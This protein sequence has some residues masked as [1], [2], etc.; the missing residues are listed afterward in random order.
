[1]FRSKLSKEKHLHVVNNEENILYDA[2]I[3]E[4]QQEREMDRPRRF[5][6]KK[7]KKESS[8]FSQSITKDAPKETFASPFRVYSS[9][10]KPYEE[11]GE[12]RE[13]DDYYHEEDELYDHEEDT[14]WEEEK[15]GPLRYVLALF[16]LI[17]LSALGWFTFRWAVVGS[18]S[19]T[20]G[21]IKAPEGPYKISPDTPGGAYIPYQDKHVYDHLESSNGGVDNFYEEQSALSQSHPTNP[22]DVDPHSMEEIAPLHQEEATQ[23]SFP[24]LS[25]IPQGYVLVPQEVLTT[26]QRQSLEKNTEK[27]K[28]NAEENINIKK[29]IKI[30]TAYKQEENTNS[31]EKDLI[32]IEKIDDL[33]IKKATSLHQNELEKVVSTSQKKQPLHTKVENFYLQLG[34]F[35][36]KK[37]AE[38]EKERLSNLKSFKKVPLIITHSG[39]YFVLKAG[40][41]NQKKALDKNNKI[42][43]E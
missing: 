5:F 1:M 26:L 8:S 35:K 27:E 9:S 2:G 34:S 11:Q 30:P 15:K 43:D 4:E 29:P 13:E 19:S 18:S 42:I 7:D 22:Q 16:L 3:E 38:R 41:F 28:N 39:D 23:T 24:L 40:P 6:K 31:S 33:A 20:I 32:K 14:Q 17:M 37:G 21:V 36:T 10:S 12:P 25:H